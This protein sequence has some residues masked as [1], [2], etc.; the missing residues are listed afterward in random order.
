MLR[1]AR[2]SYV[3]NFATKD[4]ATINAF[5]KEMTSKALLPA[6]LNE[7]LL[8]KNKCKTPDV[9]ELYALKGT[10]DNVVPLSGG[11]IVIKRYLIN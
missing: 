1:N 11:V 4:T 9:T 5:S 6:N 2:C 10:R 8:G 7:N 3:G